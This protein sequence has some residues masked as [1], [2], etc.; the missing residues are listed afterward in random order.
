MMMVERQLESHE[1]CRMVTDGRGHQDSIYRRDQFSTFLLSLSHLQD[2]MFAVP[3]T[4]VDRDRPNI[5]W[6]FVSPIPLDQIRCPYLIRLLC[7]LIIRSRI[8]AKDPGTQLTS[9]TLSLWSHFVT[10]SSEDT[11]HIL[12]Q[13]VPA[14]STL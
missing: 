6:L 5:S 4:P 1:W 10:R 13:A 12:I 14:L 2:F 8:E 3:S 9:S 11:I 7:K